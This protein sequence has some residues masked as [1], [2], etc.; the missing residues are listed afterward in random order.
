MSL[1][2]SDAL[3]A[4][5]E[6]GVNATASWHEVSGATV[7][8]IAPQVPVP[9]R[10]NSAGSDEVALETTNAFVFPV[11][12]TVTVLVIVWPT[13]TSPNASDAVSD[14]VVVGVA[15]AVGVAVEVAV[16]V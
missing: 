12:S 15:V 4:P 14:I 11:L 8:G 10:A 5:A 16:A 1:R 9:L 6:L 3:C 7:R 13:A 2:V